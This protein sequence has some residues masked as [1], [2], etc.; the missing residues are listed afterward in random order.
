MFSLSCRWTPS[1]AF[2]PEI[3]AR[4]PPPRPSCWRVLPRGSLGPR[5]RRGPYG[6]ASPSFHSSPPFPPPAP[7]PS[8]PQGVP[9]RLIPGDPWSARACP[10]FPLAPLKPSKQ[11][12]GRTQKA[13]CRC[14]K[15][16]QRASSRSRGVSA[17]GR[18]P[19]SGRGLGALWGGV[20]R[21]KR[22]A[23]PFH[24]RNLWFGG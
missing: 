14:G 23:W 5:P 3:T 12:A 11:V 24:C 22:R 16:R 10:R 9:A 19:R 7:P 17:E 1:K 18:G 15:R 2:T 13:A 21:P 4:A 8:D 6:M 20:S